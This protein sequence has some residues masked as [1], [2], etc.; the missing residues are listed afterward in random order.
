M[1]RILKQKKAFTLIEL[2]VV[3][4]IIAILAALLLPAL[5]AAKRKAQRINC[6]NN[7]KQVNLAFR[8]WEGDNR[9]SI[10]WPSARPTTARRRASTAF[11]TALCAGGHN[12]RF[13]CAC[14][15]NWA[16]PRFC[17]ARLTMPPVVAPPRTLLRALGLKPSRHYTNRIRIAS[18][19]S[20]AAMRPKPT[21]RCFWTAT[22]TSGPRPSAAAMAQ[23]M[24]SHYQWWQT[25]GWHMS[26]GLDRQRL[27]FEG[28][29]HGLGR[30]QR[31][32]ANRC[33]APGR[34][35]QLHKL[36]ALCRQPAIRGYNFP[37]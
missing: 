19:T 24:Y 36:H 3:I 15:M 34:H 29:Q 14:R 32:A 16:R 11:Q 7:L 5:A 21:H 27:A 10:P 2:L 23:P 1:K 18:A 37:Q 30:R 25:M 26:L 35:A 31:S 9:T 6:V 4:A 28:W 20:S 17:I 33:R 13:C 8:I 12:Q 22:A